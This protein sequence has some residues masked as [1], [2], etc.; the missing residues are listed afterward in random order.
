MV[1]EA[2]VTHDVVLDGQGYLLADY[3]RQ[4][5][6]RLDGVAGGEHRLTRWREMGADYWY[7]LGLVARDG[8]AAL[9]IGPAGA[10]YNAIG[11]A[12]TVYGGGGEV[13]GKTYLAAGDTL[14]EVTTSS[15]AFAS[16]TSKA[17]SSTGA[18]YGLT[19]H[20][21][22]LW[23]ALGAK[24][25]TWD[26]TTWSETV[27]A[28][29]R[30]ASYG[31]VL[32][33]STAF[34]LHWS[35]DDGSTWV[36]AAL[37]DAGLINALAAGDDGLYVGAERGLYRVTARLR[38]GAPSTAP[39]VLDV[40]EYEVDQLE[41]P[42]E[43]SASN[44]AHVATY[45]GA[46]YYGRGQ[47]LWRRDGGAA[48]IAPLSGVVN[49]LA[50]VGE[51]LVVAM[52]NADDGYW[53]WLHDGAGYYG[54]AQGTGTSTKYVAPV[55]IAKVSDCD[56]AAWSSG[57]RHLTRWLV[58][59]LGGRQFSTGAS[60]GAIA[61]VGLDGGQP[62]GE[63]VWTEVGALIGAVNGP[64]VLT[65]SPAT[66][67]LDYSTDGGNTWT[68]AGQSTPP[69]AVGSLVAPIAVTARRLW[70]A[71]RYTGGGPS[72]PLIGA[73]W[74][75]WGDGPGAG[76]RRRWVLD[77]LCSDGLA[78]LDGVGLDR[79]GRTMAAALA[80]LVGG[81]PVTLQD[82]RYAALAE[83]YTVRVV[84]ARETTPANREPWAGGGRVR[85]V[86]EEL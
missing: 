5:R 46:V 24:Y 49:G 3:E 27:T 86:C 33:R 21:D 51:Y 67:F 32:W 45:R 38:P 20:K 59:R 58:T 41:G 66:W 9:E 70:L 72:N 25:A 4:L 82:R 53:L 63:K 60:T 2:G 64:A 17:T 26:G 83:S 76:V 30:L 42:W 18:I 61:T 47:R 74:A 81:A 28:A 29:D 43:A 85:V 13:G 77:V 48:A 14:Y 10:L 12:T 54:L 71:L 78:G 19:R 44:A 23:A 40:L 65:G 84:E 22:K 79:D 55:G 57:N 62:E 56:L 75:R 6:P 7:T 37:H 31:G 35:R 36:R 15:G 34:E 8:G 50:A 1:A 11:T 52:H 80:A 73:L 69:P 16:L 68:E 39:T